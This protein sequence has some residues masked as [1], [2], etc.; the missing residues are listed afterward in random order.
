MIQIITYSE[1]VLLSIV[2]GFLGH[3]TEDEVRMNFE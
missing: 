3:L 1:R 2:D